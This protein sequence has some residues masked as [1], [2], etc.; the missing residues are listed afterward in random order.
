MSGLREGEVSR[1]MAWWSPH[2]VLLCSVVLLRGG[3]LSGRRDFGSKCDGCHRN[4]GIN[5]LSQVAF[6]AFWGGGEP[7]DEVGSIWIINILYR[8]DDNG[9][10]QILR[11]RLLFIVWNVSL[12]GIRPRYLH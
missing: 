5:I 12:G 10:H 2:D 8:R 3:R 1:K 7:D 11:V 9:P 6:S 4:I